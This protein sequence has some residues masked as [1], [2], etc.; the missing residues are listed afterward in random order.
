MKAVLP[1]AGVGTRLRPHTHTT[2]KALIHVAGKP[3]LGHIIDALIPVGVDHIVLVV[4]YLG[5]KIVDYVNEAYDIQVTVVEQKEPKG[6][7]HAIHLTEGVA[8]P[9][10]PLLIVLGDTI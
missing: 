10:E 4:G 3:I 1:V 2:P 7:G 5:N 8:E 9:D 6:L